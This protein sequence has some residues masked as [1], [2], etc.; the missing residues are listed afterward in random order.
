[1]ADTS[2]AKVSKL[3]KEVA[4]YLQLQKFEY[5]GWPESEVNLG[6]VLGL[7]GVNLRL[8]FVVRVPSN[9]PNCKPGYFG[10]EVQSTLHDERGEG[11]WGRSHE[12]HLHRLSCDDLKRHLLAELGLPCYEVWDIEDMDRV[13]DVGCA[14]AVYIDELW[15]I[16]TSPRR[17]FAPPNNPTKTP[18]MSFKDL[19]T[20]MQSSPTEWAERKLKSQQLKSDKKFN[21]SGN[22]LGGSSFKKKK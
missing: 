15:T 9:E 13:M 17:K 10:I 20:Y 4:E 14:E 7:K 1:M 8:D 2:K 12:E 19:N 11:A 22:K 5:Y 18:K 21:S 6:H 3:H 16:T